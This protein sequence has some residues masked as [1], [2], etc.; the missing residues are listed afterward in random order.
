MLSVDEALAVTAEE[1]AAR[2]HHRLHSLGA[3][4]LQTGLVHG[5]MSPWNLR[6]HA[7]RVTAIYDF[8]SSHLDARAVDIACLRRGYHDAAAQGYLEVGTLS[9]RELD[10]LWT[11]PVLLHLREQ[12]GG[13][14]TLTPDDPELSWCREQ[15][16][17]IVPY[18]ARA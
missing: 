17:K 5:D 9:D 3:A 14:R 15:F 2:A 7:G 8:G 12:F 4:S 18:G 6:H 10:A 11:V 16:R 1:F 13:G